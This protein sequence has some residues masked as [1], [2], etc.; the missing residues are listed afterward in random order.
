MEQIYIFA[1]E[2]NTLKLL[3]QTGF[4]LESV[5]NVFINYMLF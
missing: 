1:G 2:R 4:H 3:F 5:K